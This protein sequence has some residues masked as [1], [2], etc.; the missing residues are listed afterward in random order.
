MIVAT[1]LRNLYKY[2]IAAHTAAEPSPGP[3]SLEREDMVPW[4]TCMQHSLGQ[5]GSTRSSCQGAASFSLL[6]ILAFL[7][8]CQGLSGGG[9][10]QQ[11][12]PSN[13]VPAS[14]LSF[15]NTTLSFGSVAVGSN[16][17]STVT[18]TNSGS[19]AIT[20]TGVAISSQNFLLTSPTLPITLAAGQ[21]T[22]IGVTFAPNAAGA[23]N[24]TATISSDASNATA[25]IALNGSGTTTPGAGQLGLN[26][27]TEAFGNIT[28]GS[29]QA[30][31]VTL[32][33]NGGST[34]DISQIAVSGSGF[35][36]SGIAAP[37]SL[38]ASQSATFTVS[39]AP[40]SAGSA[41]GLV[42]ISSDASNS[43][44]NMALSGTGVSPGETAANPTS[45]GF[46]SVTVGNDDS[47]A[48]TITNTGGT[49][50]TISGIA[51][52]GAGF[53][54]SG[55]TTPLTLAANQSA[56]F[57]VTF[58]PTTSGN[59][60]GTVTVTSNASDSTLTIALSGTGTAAVGQLSVTPA[61]LGVGSVVVGTSGTASG[62]LKAT[63]A[64]VTVTAA[65]SNNSVFSV[66][67]LS[68]PATISAGQSLPFTVMFSPTA[69]GAASATLDFTSNAQTTTTAETLT[70]TGT[71][72]P[73]YSV[74][75]SWTASTSPDISGYNIYRAVYST[76]CG[77]F[78]KINPSLN[79]STLYTDSVVVDGTN[80]CYA[81][82]AVNSSNEESSYSNVVSNVQIPAP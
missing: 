5:E 1:H 46:G 2:R 38:S 19:A 57:N 40:Q 7:V 22:S 18:A 42:T 61:T 45:L 15:G 31:T 62:S 8:G 28:V 21:N 64:S 77:S 47:L 13:K 75:L 10:N 25:N 48:E 39:F 76:A 27:A 82:T 9:S 53:G 6:L 73:T 80:Y 41:S 12:P 52:S 49:S 23:F 54:L 69:A 3:G 14:T 70:G 4:L 44:L 56:T 16:K 24:A 17:G 11:S 68:L 36:V 60:S 30:E 20:I 43:S 71:A 26:P 79:T 34:V 65:D 37:V 74:N 81:T 78:S 72:P 32:T 33:N 29:N 35:T 59:A 51:V 63:G 50:L 66:S 58:D 55:V 67:G